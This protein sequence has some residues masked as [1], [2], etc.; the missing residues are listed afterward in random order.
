MRDEDGT[1]IRIGSSPPIAHNSSPI[2]QSPMSSVRL[3]KE[4]SVADVLNATFDVLRATWW[5]LGKSLLLIA[6]PPT[7]LAIGLFSGGG[8]Q[9]FLSGFQAGLEPN[10][11]PP[12]LPS[13]LSALGL[14]GGG[15]LVLVATLLAATAVLGVVKCYD[16][17][18]ADAFDVEHVWAVV[19]RRA[20]AVILLQVLFF[21]AIGFSAILVIIPCLG[22][23][24]WVGIAALLLVRYFFVAPAIVVLE[25]TSAVDAL[26]R[27]SG[28]TADTVGTT[29]GVIVLAYAVQ[30]ILGSIFGVPLQIAAFTTAASNTDPGLVMSAVFFGLFLVSAL[31][32]LLTA[33]LLYLVA[34]VHYF[35]LVERN[36]QA[37]LA[38]RVAQLEADAAQNTPAS[39][40]PASQEAD[41]DDPFS[42]ER[43]ASDGFSDPPSDES[44]DADADSD[45]R[46]NNASDDASDDASDSADRGRWGRGDA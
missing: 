22:I 44:S 27:S 39:N 11:P 2:P 10:A 1:P 14:I 28:L 34:A 15:L 41:S 9:A 24:A 13:V 46:R 6:G 19:K 20:P 45:E 17:R 42:R 38:Q 25:E 18:G 30:F 33:A 21:L 16:E 26:R 37:G 5:V 7:L 40:D 3:R 36:A 23:L 32:S 35:S 43:F 12:D 29:L 4:R 8:L 31:G